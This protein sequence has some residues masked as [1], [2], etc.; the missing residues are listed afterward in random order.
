MYKKISLLMLLC[1]HLA[2]SMQNG[3]R[4]LEQRDRYSYGIVI[5]AIIGM[6]T[7]LIATESRELTLNVHET[8]YRGCHHRQTIADCVGPDVQFLQRE[9]YVRFDEIRQEGPCDIHQP[10]QACICK[11]SLAGSC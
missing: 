4:R 8:L 11:H 1:S 7:Y 10:I 5:T 6:L 9:E 3:E 2:L